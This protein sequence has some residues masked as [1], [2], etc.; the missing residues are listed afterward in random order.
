MADRYVD[1]SDVEVPDIPELL[2]SAMIFALEEAKEKLKNGEDVVPFTALVVKDNLFIET[3]PGSTAEECFN[4]ARHTVQHARGAAAY[5]MCYD[6]YVEGEDENG[7]ETTFDALIA[8]GGVPGEDYG[9]AAG[10]LYEENADGELE[11]EEEI[12]YIGQA[13]NFMIFLRK[14]GEYDDDEIDAKYLGG[15]EECD[16]GDEECDGEAEP[17]PETDAAESDEAEADA[18]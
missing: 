5:V 9:Y 1:G 18:E 17:E 8:E 3:H 13:P 10:I 15:D 14:P 6:G 16:G 7:E 11:F 12:A 4:M 2:E